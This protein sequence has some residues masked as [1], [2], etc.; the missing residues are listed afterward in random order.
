MLL[1][2]P[3]GALQ[4]AFGFHEAL[5]I[6]KEIGFDA[7]DATLTSIPSEN[8]VFGKS[9]YLEKARD[10]RS[11][12]DSIGICCNQSHAPFPLHKRADEH[13]NTHIL[14]W[15]V[16]AMEIT[17]VLGGEIC[18][19]HPYNNWTPKENAER[20]YA[21]LLPYCKKYGVKVAVENMWNWPQ[22]VP[23]AV[24]CACSLPENFK[25]HMDL[26]DPEWFVACLDIGHAEMFPSQTSAA[27][28]IHTL[29]DRLQ[30][31]HVH[32]NDCWHDDHTFP[33]MG[34][35]DWDSVCEALKQTGYRGDFTFEADTPVRKF[36][37]ELKQDALTLLYKIGRNLQGRLV[38]TK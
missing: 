7:Y 24:P 36:P 15:C 12:A 31:I 22:G 13:W 23:M 28:M 8:F 5:R 26:L 9:D 19:V 21:P 34:K 17:S 18:V 2:T 32:D 20:V 10:L 30:S 25:A 14:E 37:D 16:R 29:G 3:T 38:G 6:L 27:E 11:F 1:S 35:I 4:C 33:F